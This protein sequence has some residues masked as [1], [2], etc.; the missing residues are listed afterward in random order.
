MTNAFERSWE[1]TKKSFA[2]M[3]QDKELILF[4]IFALIF[5]IIFMIGM[6]FPVI[7]T[8]ITHTNAMSIFNLAI[9]FLIYLGLSFIATFFN[10]CV[11]YT[12]KKRFEGKN[13]TFMESISFAI[14]KI[15]LIF[16]WSL[17]SATVGLILRMI[18]EFAERQGQWG[19]IIIKIMTSIIGAAWSIITIFVVPAMVYDNLGPFAAIKKS[20]QTLKKTWGESLIRYYAFGI[21]QFAFFIIAIIFGL[22]AIFL[23]KGIALIT[24]LILIAIY[25]ITMM[26]FFGLLS[27]IFNTALYHYANTGKVPNGFDQEH[28]ANA[29]TKK[30]NNN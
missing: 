13:A 10:L 15:H 11:V 4:P 18:D 6:I 7:I 14:S 24:A 16:A 2:V 29:F 20:F 1:I 12:T 30:N 17:V 21:M 27:S 23:L 9:I 22:F 25:V 28:M 8:N 5:S 26:I 3:K 19:E